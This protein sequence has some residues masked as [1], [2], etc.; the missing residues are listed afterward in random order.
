MPAPAAAVTALAGTRTGRRVVV[1]TLLAFLLVAGIVLTPLIA[2]PFAVVGASAGV[3][4]TEALG[5]GPAVKGEWGYPLAGVYTKG[6]GFGY[7]PVVG[8]S[9]CPSQHRGYDMAQGCGSTIYAAGPGEV[10]TAGVY[11]DYGNTVRIDH[12]DGLVTIY[13]HMQWNTLRV[14]VGDPVIAGTALGAEGNT[15]RSFGCHLHFEV[16]D[17]DVRLDPQPFMAARGLPLS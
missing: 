9:Y 15:G 17:H 16:R 3:P 7:G 12:G 13:G 10:I 11:L 8:C 14:S 4:A 2:I 5:G 1:G 6:R